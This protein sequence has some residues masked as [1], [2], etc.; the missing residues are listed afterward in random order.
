MRAILRVILLKI[1]YL[2]IHNNFV[3]NM[4]R[5]PELMPNTVRKYSNLI[6][7]L[8]DQYGIDPSVDSLNKFITIKCRKRQLAVKYAIKKYLKF[9]WRENLYIQLVRAKGKNSIKKKTFLSRD[10]AKDI[11]KSI[12]K[13]DHR[14]IAKIQYFTGARASE[15]I[16]IEKKRIFHETNENRIRIDIIGKG[17]KARSLYLDSSIYPE[18]HDFLI[19]PGNYLF[20]N[21]ETGFKSDEEKALKVESFYKRYYESIKG[22]AEDLGLT[23]ATH[24][25]RRS[26]ADSLKKSGTDIIE[27]KKAMGHERIETT[28]RYFKDDPEAISKTMLKHQKGI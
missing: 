27:I 22:A 16:A 15:T 14:L 19:K 12:N 23:L 2:D 1:K 25:W 11:I 26:F 24:D 10:E 13:L 20:L 5:N 18:M 4:K 6:R 3:E 9:R 8:I 17:G 28:E 21:N 7:E